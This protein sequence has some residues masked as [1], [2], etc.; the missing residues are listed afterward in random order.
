MPVRDSRRRLRLLAEVV[1][2][3]DLPLRLCLDN[4]DH[5]VKVREVNLAV[6]CNRGREVFAER[7]AQ[8]ADLVR[9]ARG[10]IERGHDAAGLDDVEDVVIEE[11][12]SRGVVGVDL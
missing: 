9:L 11:W 6:G 2:G 5:A 10:W 7:V 12:R 3:N 8:A 1:A 4:G